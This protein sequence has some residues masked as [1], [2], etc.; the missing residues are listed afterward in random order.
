MGDSGESKL[1]SQPRTP[2]HG[3]KRCLHAMQ[4]HKHKQMHDCRGDRSKGVCAAGAVRGS[5]ES[6]IE[7]TW[8]LEVIGGGSSFI[9]CSS[10]DAH[11]IPISIPACSACGLFAAVGAGDW[12]RALL[13]GDRHFSAM[14]RCGPMRVKGR[15][16]CGQSRKGSIICAC[17]SAKRPD[18]GGSELFSLSQL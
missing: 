10:P 18:I 4:M 1:I 3:A 7:S 9:L 11:H 5:R 15:E 8:G 14:L 12:L 2:D 6:R 16:R 13:C 17:I